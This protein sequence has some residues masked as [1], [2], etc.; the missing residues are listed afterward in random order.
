MIMKKEINNLLDKHKNLIHSE[1]QK[2]LSHV[3]R[4]SEEWVLNTVMI[5]G[6]DI[7]FKYNRKKRYRNLKGARVNIT[8]YPST[9]VIAGLDMEIMKAT[10]IKIS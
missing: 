2:V 4:E 6:C 10:R 1:N 5:E 3:Q 9:Q 7:P 8:Y